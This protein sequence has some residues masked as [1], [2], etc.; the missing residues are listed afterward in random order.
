VTAPTLAEFMSSQRP[1]WLWDAERARIVWANAAGRALVRRET[2]F[3][4]IDQPFD[5]EDEAMVRIKA[6]A[7]ELPHGATARETLRLPAAGG[8]TPVPCACSVHALSDG[9][10]GLL[11]VVEEGGSP[12]ES[13]PTGLA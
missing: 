7:R 12:G 13:L 4:L 10:P 1:A 6:L 8:D 2:L 9:R 11:V 5:A 3:D